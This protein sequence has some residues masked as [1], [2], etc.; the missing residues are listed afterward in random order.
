MIGKLKGVIDSYGED[1]VILDV[2]GV[3][4][5]VQCSARTLQE[6]PP[7]GQ[8]ATLSIETYV[9]EDQIRL[10]GFM[11]DVEREWFRLLQT[12]QGV[13]AK[14]ALAVLGTLK[15]ADL[16]S[17]IAMRDK[18]MVARTPGVGPKVAERIVT[19]LKD[20]APAYAEV[21]PALVRLSG[22]LEDKRAPQPI[23]DAVSA[24]VNLG[25]GQPQAAAAV[26]AAVRSA[27]EGAEVKTL[28]RLG[29]KELAK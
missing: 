1:S 9:R 5:L 27:G 29:L 25:Y 18:A 26:A 11:S 16:A 2:N 3:G 28:I 15:P 7:A 6:L 12:V 4:Y 10:F 20:K 14:V 24:L 13:G 8:V 17:A 23:S 19:E 22:A 21:D